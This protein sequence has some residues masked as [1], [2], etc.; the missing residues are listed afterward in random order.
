MR[1]SKQG[2]NLVDLSTLRLANYYKLA[3]FFLTVV[4]IPTPFLNLIF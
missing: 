3:T 4:A 2:L 1:L